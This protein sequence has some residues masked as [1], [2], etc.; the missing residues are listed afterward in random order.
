[1]EAQTI[2]PEVLTPEI[3][4]VTELEKIN[5]TDAGL[6]QLRERA[7]ELAAAGVT[8]KASYEEIHKATMV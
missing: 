7:E 3:I 8:D 5:A 4:P 1:M 6:A 2:E